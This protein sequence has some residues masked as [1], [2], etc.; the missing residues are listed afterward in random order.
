MDMLEKIT[1][2]MRNH[3]WYF[4]YSDDQKVWKRGWREKYEI[5]DLLK[6]IPLN[7][8]E[9]YIKLIPNDFRTKWFV[10]LQDFPKPP[11]ARI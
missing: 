2:L 6:K 8:L 10:E 7:E 3:D 11:E 4:E 9:I 5:M 1:K